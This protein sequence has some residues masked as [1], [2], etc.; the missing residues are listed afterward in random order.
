MKPQNILW[1]PQ[2]YL[3]LVDFGIA[4]IAI[5]TFHFL[6]SF[7]TL[8]FSLSYSS[9]LPSFLPLRDFLDYAH[10]RVPVF[11]I[12]TP[13]YISPEG[14]W[15]PPSDVFSAGVVLA[16]MVRLSIAPSCYLSQSIPLFMFYPCR[17]SFHSS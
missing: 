14:N 16:E 4:G 15:L 5:A 9:F 17:L 13:G 1:T 3:W 7:P 2:Q 12:G 6:P 11:P 8:H 10:S